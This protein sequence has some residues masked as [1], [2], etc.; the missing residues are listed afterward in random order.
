MQGK[1]ITKNLSEDTRAQLSV[2][3]SSHTAGRV[4]N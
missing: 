3:P 4:E 2:D 1:E